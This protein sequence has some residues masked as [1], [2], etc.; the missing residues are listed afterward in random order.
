M[1]FITDNFL[2]EN[3]TAER[4]YHE[5]AAHQPIIDYHCHLEPADLASNRNYRNLTEICLEG[6]H[7]K[8]RA[9][10]A[11]G[12]PEKFCT[13]DAD[14]KE[15]FLAYARTVPHTYRNPLYHWTHLELKRYFGIDTL[16]NEKTAEAVWE[17]A[18]EALKSPQLS[19]WGIL[20]NFQ[21]QVIGTTDDPTDSL[22]HHQTLSNS[23]CPAKVIPTFR[24]DKAFF[25]EDQQKWNAW[26]GQLEAACGKSCSSLNDF[27]EALGS[28]CDFF[29][30]MGARASDHGLQRCPNKFSRKREAEETFN[31]ARRGKDVSPD[32][33]EG[34]AGFV[35]MHLAEI[36]HQK[37]W[38][39]Q[40]HLGA[41]RNV[42]PLVLNTLGPD[43]GA[44][45][46]GDF[47]QAEALT[48]FLGQLADRGKL[49]KTILYNLNPADNYVFATMCGNFFEEGVPGKMQFGSGWWFLDQMEAMTWQINALSN[50]GLLSRF[51][52]MLTDS[53]SIMSYPRHE[54]FRRLLCNL[55]GTDIEKGL[56]PDDIDLAADLIKRI[57]HKNARQYF[58][59]QQ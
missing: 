38:A 15:K 49:P 27:L 50:T 4:L 58:S 10:R 42:N 24:P 18:N 35:L 21:V 40:F 11:N 16:L 47:P 48:T 8:W 17:K 6:D 46:T 23:D 31:T 53:R 39:M 20:K 7:Y 9:M 37:G 45:S 41:L 34:F 44:D 57:C 12:E 59:I 33:A 28:R 2:L 36:Y 51:V 19:T 52:G 1:T 56:L 30:E 26:V 25:V 43:K 29:D 13:G 3:K 54:Y 5:F 32:Q 14:P 55:I 22:E